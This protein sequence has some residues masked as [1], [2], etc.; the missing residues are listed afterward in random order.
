M[1]FIEGRLRRLEGCM[2]GGRCPECGLTPDGPGHIVLIDGER[3]ERSFDGDPD[4]RCSRCGR[5]LWCVI[6]LVYEDAYDTSEAAGG[7]GYRWP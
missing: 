7:G 6:R 4:E 2:Q 1:S 3:P 5:P